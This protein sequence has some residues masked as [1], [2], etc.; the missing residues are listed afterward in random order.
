[1]MSEDMKVHNRAFTLR[2]NHCYTTK[3]YIIIKSL[4]HKAADHKILCKSNMNDI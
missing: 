1:M 4:T 2:R 3:I